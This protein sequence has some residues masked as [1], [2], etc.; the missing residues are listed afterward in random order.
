[1]KYYRYT[2]FTAQSRLV[3][4]LM[5]MYSTLEKTPENI[6]IEATPFVV[7]MAF[8]VEAYLNSIGSRVLNYWDKIERV[9]WKDKVEILH[10][11]AG[12]DAQW[13][14]EPLQFIKS[15]FVIRDKLAHGKPELVKSKTYQSKKKIIDAENAEPTHEEHPD[16]YNKLNRAWVIS[17]KD[18]FRLAMQYLGSLH[19]F[20]E[21]DYLCH[22]T[23][24][25]MI[26]DENKN[27]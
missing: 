11:I 23:G 12:K 6:K 15:L 13:A 19:G 5:S 9:S 16:W 14:E 27:V 21:S 24:G 10:S 2:N 7:F 8:S 1:M 20:H 4:A 17:A 22:S 3:S 25:I 26:D 18:K